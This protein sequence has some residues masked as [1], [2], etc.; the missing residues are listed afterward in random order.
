MKIT[1]AVIVS[2]DGYIVSER[3]HIETPCK[4]ALFRL[5]KEADM[6]LHP[7]TSLLMLLAEK[8]NDEDISYFAELTTDT[9]DLIKGL[10][11]Y[12]LIDKVS[13]HETKEICGSGIRL[14]DVPGME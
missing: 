3:E 11:G 2:A 9:L 5:R 1:I 4:Q 8:Q 12:G 10:Q 7:N 6:E 14:S 13:I